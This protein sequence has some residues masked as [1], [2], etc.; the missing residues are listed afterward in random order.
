MKKSL[1][2]LL[3]VFTLSTIS[4]QAQEVKNTLKINPLSALVRVG[5]IFYERKISPSSSLQLGVAYIGLKSRDTK[6]SGL[7][8]TPEYRYFIK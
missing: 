1:Q 6:F 3:I 7:A 5:S 4:L 2:F 8:L